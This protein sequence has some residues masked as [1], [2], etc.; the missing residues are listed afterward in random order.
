M[1]KQPEDDASKE[2]PDSIEAAPSKAGPT[3]VAKEKVETL[4]TPPPPAALPKEVS[5]GKK[6]TNGKLLRYRMFDMTLDPQ[7]IAA[8]MIEGFNIPGRG[9]SI[10]VD[11]STL[12]DGWEKRVIQRG[13]GV[14][15]GKWDVFIIEEDG[16]KA[17]RSKTE[18]QKHIDEKKLPY[19]SDAFDF[20][21]DDKLK[22]LRQIWKQYIV[23]PRLSPGE[24][25]THQ[26][27][28]KKGRKKDPS[29]LAADSLTTLNKTISSEDEVFVS[30]KPSKTSKVD[31]GE[32]KL[33]VASETGQGLR[34]SI[35][36]CGKLF[37]KDKLLRQH[38]KHYHPKVF[39]QW[40]K[41]QKILNHNGDQRNGGECLSC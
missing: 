25:L 21:L 8:E 16:R 7:L 33:G 35:P 39:D 31:E 24:R 41:K 17:F 29:K 5:D 4:E 18:L 12:P 9:V 20:S 13:I 19:T 26:V 27:P 32:L 30:R 10:P 37:R 3:K 11:S 14:T 2:M 15:K 6:E 40:L 23:K 38:V 36:N 1:I 22:K 34:C 28:A